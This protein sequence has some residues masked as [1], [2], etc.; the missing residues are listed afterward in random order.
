MAN[1]AAELTNVSVNPSAFT[2]DTPP[3]P[4]T[5]SSTPAVGAMGSAVVGE[6][7]GVDD[8]G[9]A[10]PATLVVAGVATVA[11]GSSGESLPPQAAATIAT[12]RRLERL[13]MKTQR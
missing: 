6:A 7:V 4:A 13:R 2:N 11:V 3:G 5:S 10:V 12:T 1:T 8:V 9:A